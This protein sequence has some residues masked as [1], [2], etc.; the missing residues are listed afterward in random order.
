M[1]ELDVLI[2][3]AGTAGQTAA[4]DLVA[5]GY[6]VAV[7]EKSAKPG[8]VCALYGCQAKKWFYEVTELVA[9]S[10]HLQGL[11]ITAPPSVSWSAILE[12]KNSFTSEVPQN[13]V[14]SLK[15]NGVEYLEGEA[16]FAAPDTV[17]VNGT[18]Y[19]P[20]FTIIAAGATPMPL[21]IE[22]REILAT[23]ND[24]LDLERLP[25][26]ITFIGGGFIS[27]EFA[28]FAARLGVEPREVNI[29][30]VMDRPLGPFDADMVEELVKATRAEGIQVH[31]GISIQSIARAASGFVVHLASGQTI[32]TDLVVHG[33]GR[34]ADID[35]LNLQA[36][37]ITFN[38]RGIEVDSHMTTSNPQVFAVGDSA[39]T[40]QLARVADQEAHVA[41]ASIVGRDNEEPSPSIDYSAAPA[42]LFTYP[43]LGLVGKTE[44]ELIKEGTKYWKSF[45]K[46]VS[47]PTYRRVGMKHAA[48]KILVDGDGKILGA[49]VLSDNATGLINTFKQAMIDGTTVAEL[50]KANIMSPYPSR[51]SD[52]IYMLSPLLD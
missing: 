7:V 24:F 16:V 31:T 14:A 17:M 40:L 18:A 38:R 27:F 45:A 46:E 50:H 6:R 34:V 30:E 37:G 42:M 26:R 13:T 51:E 43:M 49:H 22:G 23:S 4:F 39:A 9:R 52:I 20:R 36:A 2:I 48:Y 3:G 25:K 8:G 15:G 10:R 5:E 19:K 11:G 28:H 33:A 47:W 44:D 32:E 12:A 21:P 1:K 35:G 41:A 29:L